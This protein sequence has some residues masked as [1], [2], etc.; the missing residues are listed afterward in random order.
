MKPW[1][2]YEESLYEEGAIK[3]KQSMRRN[4]DD[5]AGDFYIYRGKGS[6]S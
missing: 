2:A 5:V 1:D 6:S 3:R 4:Y